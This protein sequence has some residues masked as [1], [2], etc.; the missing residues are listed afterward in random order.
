MTED[1][2]ARLIRQSDK[3]DR[4]SGRKRTL[5]YTRC[6]EPD[7]LDIV[8]RGEVGQSNQNGCD[9]PAVSAYRVDNEIVNTGFDC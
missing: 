1:N 6:S 7:Y 9:S 4:A 2:L 3:D 5:G 8:V